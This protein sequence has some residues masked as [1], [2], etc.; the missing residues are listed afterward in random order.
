MCADCVHVQ[1]A[2]DVLDR[3]ETLCNFGAVKLFTSCEIEHP[4]KVPI[5]PLTT[6]YDYSEF[7]LKKAHEFV[8]T[9]HAL[10][11]QHDGYILNPGAW[12]PSWLKYDYMGPLWIHKHP[13]GPLSV[14]S[15]GFSLRSKRLMDFVAKAQPPW[16]EQSGCPPCPHEDGVIALTLRPVLE[17]NGFIFASPKEAALFAQGGNCDPDYYVRKPFGF[18]GLWSNINL[19][20]GVVNTWVPRE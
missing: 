8:E 15:G 3:C 12:N 18:H 1:S 7:M 5:L 10:I 19:G 11:V 17:A 16:L 13:I 20:L 4:H 14:G 2:I 6:L 9:E